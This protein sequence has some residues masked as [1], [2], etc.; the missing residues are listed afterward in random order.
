MLGGQQINSGLGLS[1]EKITKTYTL[2]QNYA[3]ITVSFDFLRIDEWD[4]GENLIL[5][6]NGINKEFNIFTYAFGAA[7]NL[8]GTSGLSNPTATFSSTVS[9]P[10]GTTSLTVTL[11][12]TTRY[13]SLYRDESYG[14]MNLQITAT[15]CPTGCTCCQAPATGYKCLTCVATNQYLL[16][17]D[18]CTLCDVSCNLCQYQLTNCINCALGY[19][20]QINGG[21]CIPSCPLYYRQSATSCDRCNDPFCLSCPVAIG[22]CSQCNTSA[23]L[24]PTSV[25]TIQCPD[26]YFQNTFFRVCQSCTDANCLSCKAG[27]GVCD[28]CSNAYF[29]HP[30][31]KTCVAACPSGYK[32]NSY[33][34]GCDKCNDTNCLSCP[35]SVGVCTVC[36]PSTFLVPTTGTCVGGCPFSFATSLT[37]NECVPCLDPNCQNCTRA[38][39]VCVQCLNNYYFYKQ[40]QSCLSSCPSG[41]QSNFVARSCV[42]CQDTNCLTC[43]TS[44]YVCQACKSGK[45]LDAN[46]ACQDACPAGY[47]T[48]KTS[49]ACVACS[50][51]FCSSCSAS[52]Y[53]CD[54]CISGYFY[55]KTLHYCLQNTCGDGRRTFLTIG[56][57]ETCDDGNK[58]SG[59]GC[60]S[61][62]QNEV[63]YYCS[64][65]DDTHIDICTFYPNNYSCPNATIYYNR[66]KADEFVMYFDLNV[67]FTQPLNNLFFIDILN[68]NG[69]Q[70]Y[71]SYSISQMAA[72]EGYF[73][74]LLIKFNFNQSFSNLTV[75]ALS[76]L[77]F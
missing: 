43:Q 41:Y 72:T 75:T 23:F 42:Q 69:Y 28:R 31:L 15:T 16:I 2:T 20:R 11:V 4:S 29:V 14:I 73:T 77:I 54:S 65:G 53:K 25:C 59:D 17:S 39:L 37:N 52:I 40:S 63:S 27:V 48:N 26:R 35:N 13:N 3:D 8:C 70:V 6:I 50:D 68:E 5:S 44:T 36:N 24:M 71:S 58:V 47:W 12:A 46:G 21:G 33:T 56:G 49:R 76:P 22:T 60:S 7:A 66:F 51:P 34:G 30:V 38:S 18:V 45:F 32:P 19:Y 61:T 10:C 67:I 62:C 57:N 9:L 64:G 55:H 74:R 1:P